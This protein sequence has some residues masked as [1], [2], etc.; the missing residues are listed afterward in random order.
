MSAFVGRRQLDGDTPETEGTHLAIP[1][2]HVM[3]VQC[4]AL[5][6]QHS[7]SKLLGTAVATAL[8]ICYSHYVYCLEETDRGILAV[9]RELCRLRGILNPIKCCVTAPSVVKSSSTGFC[10]TMPALRA[11]AIGFIASFTLLLSG[12]RVCQLLERLL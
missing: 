1:E 12:F 7:A 4:A 2:Q 10:D 5:C 11:T 3:S 9:K 6:C 8:E